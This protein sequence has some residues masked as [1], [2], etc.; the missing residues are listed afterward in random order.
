[1]ARSESIFCRVSEPDA[2]M[3]GFILSFSLGISC[4]L[5]VNSYDVFQLNHRGNELVR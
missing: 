5:L 4:G 3:S 1:M 2:N